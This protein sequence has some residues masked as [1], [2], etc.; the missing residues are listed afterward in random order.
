MGIHKPLRPLVRRLCQLLHEHR[1]HIRRLAP[2]PI[3]YLL[4]QHLQIIPMHP[5]VFLVTPYRRFVELVVLS[6]QRGDFRDAR[7]VA[8][9]GFRREVAEDLQRFVLDLVRTDV[10]G[11]EEEVEGHEYGGAEDAAADCGCGSEQFV[12]AGD[13]E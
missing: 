7:G 8:P 11:L 10:E 13:V 3:D 9:P 12:F 2:I 4:P 5:V 1:K 6:G